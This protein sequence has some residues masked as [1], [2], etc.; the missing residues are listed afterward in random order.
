MKIGKIHL[1]PLFFFAIM[2]PIYGYFEASYVMLNKM[3]ALEGLVFIVASL[4]LGPLSRLFPKKFS[5]FLVHRKALGLWGVLFAFL[6]GMLS[7]QLFY[8]FDF[9]ALLSEP[10]GI[11]VVG[12]AAALLT[13]FWL[14]FSSGWVFTKPGLLNGIIALALLLVIGLTSNKW[15]EKKMGYKKWKA[16]QRVSYA[17]VAVTLAHFF[18]M[19]QT[20]AGL[21][22]R[23]VGIAIFIF[24]L[25]V[26]FA[27]FYV[28]LLGVPEKGDRASLERK[29]G[30]I[31][32]ILGM[33]FGLRALGWIDQNIANWSYALILIL[34]GIYVFFSKK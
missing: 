7:F 9:R 3:L 23:P 4:L 16:L 31:I 12:G 27:R 15:S 25:L 34:G 18:L 33:A 28:L 24:A 5:R 11:G 29:V 13:K 10:E 22:I 17:A 19:E 20:P 8:S 30:G 32:I 26:L 1:A 14:T 2:W 6:H 21:A